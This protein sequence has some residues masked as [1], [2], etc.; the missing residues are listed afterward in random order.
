MNESGSSQGYQKVEGRSADTIAA[1]PFIAGA[2]GFIWAAVL[3]YVVFVARGLR[4]VRAEIDDLKRK[5]A[6]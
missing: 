2:Y 1:N 5:L 4:Q 3:I 6:G